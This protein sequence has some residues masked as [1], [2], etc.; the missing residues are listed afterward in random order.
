MSAGSGF[1]GAGVLNDVLVMLYKAVVISRIRGCDKRALKA[2]CLFGQ[3]YL[4][5][6]EDD[7]EFGRV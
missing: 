6:F 1:F 3:Q 7:L 5:A 4:H 2:L